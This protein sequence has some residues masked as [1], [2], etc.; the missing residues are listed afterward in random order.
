MSA[1]L[2]TPLG[3]SCLKTFPLSPPLAPHKVLAELGLTADQFIDLCILCGC[4]YTEKIAGI[5]PFRALQVGWCTLAGVSW[6]SV[7][8][9]CEEA[10]HVHYAHH[11]PQRADHHPAVDTETWQLGSHSGGTGP[12]KIQGEKDCHVTTFGG[13]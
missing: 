6:R 1:E 12:G 13:G 5:G 7:H 4:D 2:T 8:Q 11:A 9:L 10:R 3:V